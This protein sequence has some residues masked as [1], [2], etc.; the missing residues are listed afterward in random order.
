MKNKSIHIFTVLLSIMIF[1]NGVYAQKPCFTVSP[2]RGCAPL[3]IKVTECTNGGTVIRYDYGEKPSVGVTALTTHTY[4]NLGIYTITQSIAQIGTDT[5]YVQHQVEVLSSGD[6]VY[7]IDYCADFAVK[8]TIK[9]KIYDS[10]SISWG[11]GQTETLT[12]GQTSTHLF[13]SGSPMTFSIKGEYN[14]S[15]CGKTVTQ[16]ITPVKD[17]ATPSIAS[18]TA[19]NSGGIKAI[20]SSANLGTTSFIQLKADNATVNAQQSGVSPLTSVI[21]PQAANDALY[22]YRLDYSSAC[23]DH[24]SSNAVAIPHL[25]ITTTLKDL[26]VTW[27][28]PVGIT[29]FSFELYKN[30]T[31]IYAGNDIT[32]LDK[33]VV[34][35]VKYKYYLKTIFPNAYTQSLGDSLVFTSTNI[36]AAVTGLSAS[37][38]INNAL[39]VNW[40]KSVSP[41]KNGYKVEVLQGGSVKQTK[42]APAN[43]VTFNPGDIFQPTCFDVLFSDSCDNIAKTSEPVCP[44]NL[45]G[46]ELAS[47]VNLAWT[48]YEANGNSSFEYDITLFDDAGN[49]LLTKDAGTSLASAF[50]DID[51]TIQTKRY[52]I[53]LKSDN[54]YSNTITIKTPS[55]LFLPTAFSPN[56][57]GINDVFAA[58]GHYIKT[59]KMAVYSSSGQLIHV[60]EG[61]GNGWD[62]HVNGQPAPM[63]MYNYVVEATDQLGQGFNKKGAVTLIR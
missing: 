56:G 6:P 63:G 59:F 38:D 34:C 51:T 26:T 53:R 49:V 40:T 27:Q 23:A 19:V 18:V 2:V 42:I 1:S 36:P 60:A 39:T 4:K 41:V 14:P 10:F 11:D 33:D 3:D 5:N 25:D 30:G 13:T 55:T 52:R 29:G 7:Q 17:L 21:W 58:K 50:A 12:Q 24:Y 35:G 20:V 16:T 22:H 28:N 54:I 61:M 62:G 43:S 46:S 15:K 9:D 45:Q 48:A 32:Y 31:K 37:Y 44:I 47:Q 8:I 57:D